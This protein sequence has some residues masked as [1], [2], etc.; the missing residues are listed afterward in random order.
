MEAACRVL[1]ECRLDK[2]AEVAAAEMLDGSYL[3]GMTRQ[4]LRRPPFGMKDFDI[5]K[6]TS[7]KNGWRPKV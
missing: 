7:V 4:Q 2:L 3:Q 1:R 5:D 6:F